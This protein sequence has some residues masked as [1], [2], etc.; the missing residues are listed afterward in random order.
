MRAPDSPA[1]TRSVAD[2]FADVGCA[3]WLHATSLAPTQPTDTRSSHTR[4]PDTG[5]EF[6]YGAD[7]PVV[8]ASVYKVA[9]LVSLMR[10][11]DAADIDLAEPVR[12]DPRAWSAGSTGLGVLHDPVTLS[13]RDLATSMMTVSDN[14]AADVL[15]DR[16]GLARVLADL[17]I[18]GLDG[19]RIVGNMSKLQQRLREE[20]G[21]S[22]VAEAFAVLADPDTDSRISAYDAAHASAATPRLCTSLLAL[23]WA[24]AVA[25]PSS[26]EFIRTCMRRQVFTHRLA[27]GFGSRHVSVA[28]KT[29]TL[30]A[31]RNEIGVVEFPGEHPIAIA[32]FTKSARSD[33][34][35]P[36]VD[37]AIGTVGRTV[38]TALRR[39][40]DEPSPA[41]RKDG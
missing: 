16:V 27:S 15:L 29:G 22:T 13:W 21:T 35:L 30:A 24:D 20:T 1:L 4:W 9:V 41:C 34:A 2:M 3:G 19:I 26:C 36:D 28:G 33:L 8:L 10:L 25:A 7:T 31:I 39:P 14:V 11:A 23:I 18:L 6:S 32:I 5:P 12:V 37:R 40:C 17:T 38:V